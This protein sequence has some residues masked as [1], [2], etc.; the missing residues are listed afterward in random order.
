VRLA[1]CASRLNAALRTAAFVP[2]SERTD[3]VEKF[4]IVC[5]VTSTIVARHGAQLEA[6]WSRN[7][8][9]FE[10]H[11]LDA[12]D[13]VAVLAT[14]GRPS[15]TEPE[16]RTLEAMADQLLATL[17]AVSSD[18][19]I[20][21][22]LQ[23]TSS[24][25]QSDKLAA[26]AAEYRQDG[27]REQKVASAFF[28]TCVLLLLSGLG[29]ILWGLLHIAS[30]PLRTIAAARSSPWSVFSMYLV[31]ALISMIA[32]A[33]IVIQAE[34]HRRA[35]QEATRLA[36]QFDAIEAYLQPMSSPVRDMVRASLAPRLFSRILSDDDPMREPIWPT[37]DDIA[38]ASPSPRHGGKQGSAKSKPS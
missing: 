14:P 20:T 22:S 17:S 2:A 21:T 10:H 38:K 24:R 7:I 25:R 4:Q 16:I 8:P 23:P 1:S 31:A 27:T 32:A 18:L 13:Y 30:P 6:S 5:S 29:F 28:L 3:V 37:A 34:R 36:R 26:V 33:I 9:A 12:T 35:A 19:L 11:L 15:L